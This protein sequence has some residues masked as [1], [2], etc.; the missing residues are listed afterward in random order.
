[1][2]SILNLNVISKPDPIIV[3]DRLFY[4]DDNDNEDEENYDDYN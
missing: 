4:G 2:F 3:F 1:M